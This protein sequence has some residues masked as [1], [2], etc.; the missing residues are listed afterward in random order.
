MLQT[1]GAPQLLAAEEGLAP[2]LPHTAEII[3]GVVAFSLLLYLLRKRVAPLFDRSYQ[4][5][6]KGIQEGVAQAENARAEAARELAQAQQSLAQVDATVGRMRSEAQSQRAQIVEE[7]HEEGRAEAA[8]IIEVAH[9]QAQGERQQALA[10]LRREVGGSVAVVAERIVQEALEDDER[11]RR[12]V[13]R[14]L[15]GLESAPSSPQS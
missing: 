15:S 1:T 13:D 2:F 14:F 9:A 4:E 5:R 6:R 11:Q 7:A 12:L 8:R 10:E 3:I